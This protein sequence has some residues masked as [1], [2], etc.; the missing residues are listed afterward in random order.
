MKMAIMNSPEE[1][2]DREEITMSPLFRVITTNVHSFV[3]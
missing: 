2:Q 3:S 1:E